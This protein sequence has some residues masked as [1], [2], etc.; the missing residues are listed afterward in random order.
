MKKI[1]FGMISILFITFAFAEGTCKDHGYYSGSYCEQCARNTGSN[2]GSKHSNSGHYYDDSICRTREVG[3]YIEKTRIPE[4]NQNKTADCV[5]GYKESYG[6][7]EWCSKCK[8][9]YPMGTHSHN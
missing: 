2:Q 5:D 8:K 7:R 6:E 4:P 1:I 3:N 9:Y